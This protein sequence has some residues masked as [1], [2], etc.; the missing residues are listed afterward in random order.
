MLIAYPVLFYDD[1][2]DSSNAP[3]FVHIPYLDGS[4]QGGNY[5]RCYGYGSRCDGYASS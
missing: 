3:Y 2:T 4:S 1:D 5:P